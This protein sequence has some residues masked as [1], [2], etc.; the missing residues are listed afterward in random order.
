[1]RRRFRRRVLLLIAA[2][3]SL[4]LL[5]SLWLPRLSGMWLP[6]S[7][8][9]EAQPGSAEI[10][11]DRYGIPHIFAPDLPALYYAFGWAQMKA[12]GD[13]VLRLYGQ[14]RGRG[15][16][17]WGEKYADT[18]RWVRRM[19]VPARAGR[20][21]E[22][23]TPEYRP[24]LDAFAAGMNAYARAHPAAIA[25]EVEV[26]LPVTPVDPIAH[27]Q[28]VIL[29]E[30]V[31]SEREVS[32]AARNWPE[33]S[34]GSN[35]WAIGPKRSASGRAMLVAN[36]HLPWSD[37]FLWFEAQLSAPGLDAYGATLVGQSIIGIGFTDRLG[38]THT[39]NTMDGQDLYEVSLVNGGYRYDGRV[40][41]FEE[42][43]QTLKIRRPDGSIAEEPLVVRRTVH[44]P[45]VAEKAGQA[46]ALRVVGLDEPNVGQQ[47]LD[48]L[49][50]RSLAGFEE[51]SARLQMPFFTTMYADA[52]GRIM[53]LFGGRT[54]VR[55]GGSWR[56]SGIVPGDR[57]ATL[58]T[59]T[60]PYADLPKVVDP[61]SGWLQ[62]ANDPPWTTTFPAAI[63]AGDYPSYMAP[64]F[65]HFR[66]QRSARMLDEKPSLSFDDVVA[67]KLSTR[68]EASDRIVDDLIALAKPRGGKAAE[69]AAVL[70]RWD[71]SADADSRGAVLFE[72]FF[73]EW[74]RRSGAGGG[75]AV[76]WDEKRPRTTPRG[77]ANPEMALAAL[78]AAA[79]RVEADHRAL[80]VPW[81]AVYRL[82]R[83]GVDLP[84][85]GGPQD[86]GIF[87][88]VGF[89]RAAD[90]TFEAAG[91]DSYVAVVEF[92]NPVRAMALLSTG[93]FSQPG[94]PHRTDQL[95]LFAEKKLRS[96]WRTRAEI[97]ANLERREVVGPSRTSSGRGRS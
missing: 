96:V 43:R 55:P 83:D 24:L 77:I 67:A 63:A 72:A 18:D 34:A 30:F 3:L 38:W 94:S 88:V 31:T 69:A 16:E 36:P 15:A 81:G 28:R 44:G 37:L 1:M 90:R 35:A 48:M 2:A 66:A 7:G 23:Q 19:D 26:V 39:V 52:D 12:H 6:P 25:D 29:F 20:W 70:A 49:R 11:W 46:L 13:L 75:F 10:L 50:A 53:H 79:A 95:R 27:G 92:S 40:R 56:W 22:R 89:R 47:Y 51:A 85:N 45:I 32:A 14:A 57:P 68:M 33:T 97:E 65:M 93:N 58:W 54:P 71:R 17:Y 64:R 60:H 86:L 84:A 73:R 78:E 8:G 80:D 5:P 41:A 91:G 42:D 82:R 62:N 76:K 21:Y 9:R 87:R 4:A 61:P 74:T 59:R